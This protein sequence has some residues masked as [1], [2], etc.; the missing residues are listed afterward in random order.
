[1]RKYHWS[2]LER[3]IAARLE[4][5]LTQRE[6]SEKMGMSHSYLNKCESGKRAIDIAELWVLSRIHG[7]PMSYFAPSE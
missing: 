7:K 2:V 4:A 1:M 6:V 5:V 3:L